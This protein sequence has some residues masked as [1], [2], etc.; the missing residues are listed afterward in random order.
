MLDSSRRYWNKL[1]FMDKLAHGALL[2]LAGI[3]VVV[4]YWLLWPYEIYEIDQPYEVITPVVA[5]GDIVEVRQTYC[6]LL[7]VPATINIALVDGYVEPIRVIESNTPI[8]C[9]D[10]ISRTVVIPKLTVPGEYKIRYTFHVHPNP[11]RTVTVTAESDT[12]TVVNN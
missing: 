8:G 10:R 11:I 4:L 3:T 9:Y 5:P 6:K 12:F 7:P 1:G 2:L